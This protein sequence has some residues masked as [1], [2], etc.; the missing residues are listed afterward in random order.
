MPRFTATPAVAEP[1]AAVP[2][3]MMTPASAGPTMRAELKAIELRAMAFDE[4]VA[5]HEVGGERLSDRHVDGV[6]QAEH[7]AMTMTIQISTDA[8]GGRA[9]TG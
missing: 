6:H 8:G 1:V 4:Q 2:A 9:G 5:R 3:A 7:S